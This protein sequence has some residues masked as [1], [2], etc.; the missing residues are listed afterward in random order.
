MKN[1]L[2]QAVTAIIILVLT[3]YLI[4]FIANQF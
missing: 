1:L 3:Y 2:T 4:D